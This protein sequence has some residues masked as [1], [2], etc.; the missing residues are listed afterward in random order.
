MDG[1]SPDVCGE[2]LGCR[3]TDLRERRENAGEQSGD[4]DNV[5]GWPKGGGE[6]IVTRG[7]G[8]RRGASR[9]QTD[10]LERVGRG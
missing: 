2:E 10:R 5:V 1:V 4:D 9:Q 7:S 3:V 8:R 6:D